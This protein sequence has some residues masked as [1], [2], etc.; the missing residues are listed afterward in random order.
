MLKPQIKRQLVIFGVLTV[1]ALLVLGI[2]YLRLPSLA[3]IGQ[4]DYQADLPAAGG[5]YK[6]A[7]VTYGGAVIGRVTSV[8]PTERGAR[9]TLRVAKRF[10]IP[11]DVTANVHSVSAIGEQYLD[12]VSAGETPGQYLKPGQTITK[13]TVP[14]SIGPA[15]DAAYRGLAA[16]PTDKIAA[17]LD[18]TATAVGGLGPA[19]QRLVDA[20]TLLVGDTK[21]H[22]TELDD[23]VVN[24]TPI[25]ESQVDSGDAIKQWVGNF[26]RLGQQAASRD[27]TVKGILH[28][29]PPLADQVNALFRDSKDALPQATANLAVVTEMVKRYNRNLEQ[30]LVFLPQAASI[31]QSVSAT[32]P[33]RASL[34]VGLGA[35]PGVPFIIPIPPVPIPGL[36]PG[37]SLNYP[38]PCLTGYLPASQWRSFAD[39]SPA[40]LTEEYY[41]KIPQETPANV[42]RGVRNMPCVDVPGKRAPTPTACRSDEPYVPLGTN[43]WYGDPNQIRNCPAPG[44]RCDQPVEP[45]HVIPAPSVNNGMN[46]LPADKVE[47]TPPAVND[48][49]TRPGT[50]HVNCN[51]QQPNPCIYTPGGG[52]AA[53]YNPQSGEVIGPDGVRFTLDDST[54][55]GDDGWKEMLAPAG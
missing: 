33:G 20:T 45:G 38:P 19:L 28:N 1:A 48:P 46:P 44:A 16:L 4:N 23:I 14:E 42:V 2:Y 53:V 49:L 11:A 13:G 10:R 6:T 52:P 51:G 21:Q 34:D 25:I 43:P 26:N 54:K 9:A 40:D 47:A 29:L 22:L 17:A 50:G 30:V 32:H 41:C 35:L 5:L 27:E 55:I 39:T 7:N 24:S 37:L 31:G 3:G 15:L 12:L 8:E 18:E 36:I